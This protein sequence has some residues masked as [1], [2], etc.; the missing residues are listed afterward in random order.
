[1]KRMSLART[2]VAACAIAAM[3]ACD[4]NSRTIDHT[5]DG[6]TTADHGAAAERPAPSGTIG[7]QNDRQP[8]P[9]T[10]S[11]CLQKGRC[12][13]ILTRINEPTQSV[14]TTGSSSTGV[15]EREQMRSAS[16]AYR[17]N[18]TGDVKLDALVGKEVRVI[19]TVAENADLP[20]PSGDRDTN[21]GN[22]DRRNRDE[23]KAGDLTKVDAT[24]VTVVADTC[25]GAESRKG[26][27]NQ[28][29]GSD[30]RP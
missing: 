6:G 3:A 16:G 27:V 20:R 30:R 18:P 5:A 13:Y 8:T 15:A 29:T 17:I 19:G 1:M 14:G 26:V 10:V 11:G 22:T 12:D 28:R 24:T 2:S 21:S 7:A 4:N 9:I 23:V 25:Q